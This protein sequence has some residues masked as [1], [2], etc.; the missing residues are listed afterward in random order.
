MQDFDFDSKCVDCSR[1]LVDAGDELVCPE[2]GIVTEKAVIEV[3]ATRPTMGSALAKQ[4]LGSYLGPLEPRRRDLRSKGVSGESSKVTYLKTISDHLDREDSAVYFC[5]K[6]AERVSEKLSLPE[7]VLAQSVSVMRKVINARQS[8]TGAPLAAVSAYALIAACRIE[9]VTSVS[10]REIVD[11]YRS[12]G[13]KVKASSIIK[14]SIDSPVRLAPR[15]PEHYLSRVIAKLSLDPKLCRALDAK[16]VSITGYQ[17]QLRSEALAIITSVDEALIAG[18]NPCALAATAVY[19]AEVALAQKQGRQRML[20][21]RDLAAV[22]DTAEYTVREQYREIFS[23][24]PL[25][26]K[27]PEPYPAP[28][29]RS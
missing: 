26:S 22:G 8:S 10:V 29:L 14:L 27:R 3:K 2:C 7:V 17:N 24:G 28:R 13:R 11:V 4:A 12:L 16:G 25:K 20:T 23:Q 19:A 9:G 18:H 1:T 6:L 15:R 5:A 21:Q